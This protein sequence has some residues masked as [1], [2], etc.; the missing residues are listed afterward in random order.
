[1]S[2]NLSVLALA[3][4]ISARCR[5]A[6]LTNNP[7]LVSTHISFLCPEIA[8]LFGANVFASA[9]FRAAKPSVHVFHGCLEVLGV[10][11]A[12]ALFIDE[13]AVNVTGARRPGLYGHTFTCAQTLADELCGYSLL[14]R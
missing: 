8:E 6:V 5:I 9:S 7:Q 13:L 4:E 1:M 10:T 3:A 12:E 2:A 14:D 11:P